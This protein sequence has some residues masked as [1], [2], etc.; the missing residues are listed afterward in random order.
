MGGTVPLGYDWCERRLVVNE[1]EAATVRLIFQR[2]LKLRSVRLLKEELARDG[3]VSKARVSSK[4]NQSGGLP[5]GRGALYELLANPIY[6]G[7]IRH[8]KVR[9]PGQHQAVVDRAVWD[10]V[11]D[12]LREQAVHH[13]TMSRSGVESVGR[14]AVRRTR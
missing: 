4:G 13:R 12:R 11:Q 10:K 7:E 3:V 5:F 1:A 9:H 14:Q 8:R 6:L 2:Y